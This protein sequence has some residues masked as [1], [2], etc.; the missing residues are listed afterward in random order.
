MRLP[1]QRRSLPN[2]LGSCQLHSLL[3]FPLQGMISLEE[4]H[5]HHCNAD[6]R[7]LSLFGAVFDVTSSEKG[8]G[9]DGACT[10]C[11]PFVIEISC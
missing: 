11:E 1:L 2:F 10:F 3:Q 4:L 5:K 7:L 6:R 8:Y 9:K